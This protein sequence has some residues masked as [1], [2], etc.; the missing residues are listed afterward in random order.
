MVVA[1]Y[2]VQGADL[3]LTTPRRPLEASGTSGMKVAFNGGLNLS[4]LDG[5]WCEAYKPSVGW[6]IGR[7]EVYQDQSYQDEVEANATYNLLEKEIVPLFYDRG[8]DGL[9]RGWIA[10]MKNSLKAICPYFNTHRMVEEYVQQ[11]YMPSAE[12]AQIL[13]A[14][15]LAKAKELARWKNE[16]RNRW[17]ELR[18]VSVEADVPSEV[19]VGSLVEVRAEVYLGSLRPEDISVELYQGAVDA[20]LEIRDGTPIPMIFLERSG[21]GIASFIGSIPCS[22]SGL[23]GYALRI[24]PKNEYLSNPFE[25]GLILW[26]E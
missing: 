15:D 26:A 19:T 5:W 2:L 18:I 23:R 8:A 6:A 4:V 12:R 9:P 3:W 16:M 25:P 24:V 17:P 14:E 7:G 21:D 11:M 20:N 10:K 1:R 22:V 13:M